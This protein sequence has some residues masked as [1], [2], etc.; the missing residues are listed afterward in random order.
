MGIFFSN[1]IHNVGNIDTKAAEI[2]Y[3]MQEVLWMLSI[4][5]CCAF[6]TKNKL[7]FL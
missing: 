6:S 2:I 4:H 5:S 3:Q 1:L 7:E